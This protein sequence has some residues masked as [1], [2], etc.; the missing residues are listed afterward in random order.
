MIVWNDYETGHHRIRCPSCGRND[1]DKTAGLK[2]EADGKGVFHCFRCGQVESHHPKDGAVYRPRIRPFKAPTTQKHERLTEWG[3][4][5]WDACSPLSGVATAYLAHRHCRIP[6][7]DGHLRWHPALKHPRGHIG[8][9]LVALVTEAET[10]QPLS[11]HRTWIHATGKANV[12]TPRMP[13]AN[14]SLQGGCIRLWPDDMVTHGLGI[15]EGIETALSL[16]WA[17]TPVWATIDAGHMKKFPL[18]GGIQTLVIGQDQD[19]AGQDAAKACAHRWANA[20]REVLITNQS[21]NDLNDLIQE[22]A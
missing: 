8:P 4:N 20:D 9:A 21:T 1:R 10:C 19:P 6:P 2:I 22:A 12:D 17:Y 13:L 7:E 14:H 15:A 16:A 5:L 11:L 18:L 3:L